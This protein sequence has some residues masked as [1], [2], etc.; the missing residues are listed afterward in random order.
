MGTDV[1]MFPVLEALVRTRIYTKFV[2][3][4]HIPINSPPP[5][6]G[7]TDKVVFTAEGHHTSPYRTQSMTWY[8]NGASSR[9]VM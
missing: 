1:S 9:D 8:K 4:D 7:R 2:Y 6:T 5:R 3:R